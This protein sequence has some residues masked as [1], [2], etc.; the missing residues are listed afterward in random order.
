MSDDYFEREVW[1]RLKIY[2]LVFGSIFLARISCDTGVW[3]WKYGAG[4]ITDDRYEITDAKIDSCTYSFW[5]KRRMI[6]LSGTSTNYLEMNYPSGKSVRFTDLKNDLQI[7]S[8][9][10][11][12]ERFGDDFLGRP[13][14]AEGQRDF[15]KGL[16]SVLQF[17]REKC[18]KTYLR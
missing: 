18:I 8:V 12:G 5:Q 2:P 6:F 11:N 17:K 7:D 9:E 3:P 14:L 15:E 16:E 1:P 13:V 10:V 4:K